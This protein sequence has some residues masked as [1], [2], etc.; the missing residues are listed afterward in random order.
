LEGAS[1]PGELV[2]R[3]HALGLPALALTD[4]DGVYGIVRAH[5]QAQKL[6]LPIVI[7]AQLTVGDDPLTAA[8]VVVLASDRSGYGK[9]CRIISLGRT[10]RPKG[11]SLVHLDELVTLGDG[12]IV[13][14]PEPA[15]IPELRAAFGERLYALVAR[16]RIAAERPHEARLR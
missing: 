11:E 2:E 9:L 7:G 8:H 16:H 4:R 6:G 10:R 5:V 13:L 14:C 1:H 12:V 15:L 3:A